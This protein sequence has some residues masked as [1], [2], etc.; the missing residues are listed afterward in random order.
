MLTLLITY[1]NLVDNVEKV[2]ELLVVGHEYSSVREGIVPA[3]MWGVLARNKDCRYLCYC[4]FIYDLPYARRHTF[5][6]RRPCTTACP[7][8]W[9]MGTQTEIVY[10][11]ENIW[12]YLYRHE[13]AQGTNHG[14][15]PFICTV[16]FKPL[17]KFQQSTG[18]HPSLVS[19]PTSMV[20]NIYYQKLFRADPDPCFISLEYSARIWIL[21]WSCTRTNYYKKLPTFDKKI[22]AVNEF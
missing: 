17:F 22:V 4:S 7:G 11:E 2:A 9:G 12:Y 3:H 14:R 1:L 16:L 8:C 10:G 20:P 21:L 15:F 5:R 13:P 6:D 18:G 19:L